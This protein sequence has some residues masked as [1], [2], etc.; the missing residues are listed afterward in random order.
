MADAENGMVQLA[1]SDTSQLTAIAGNFMCAPVLLEIQLTA[2]Q[3]CT[4]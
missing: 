1:L 3:R 2:L 4:R